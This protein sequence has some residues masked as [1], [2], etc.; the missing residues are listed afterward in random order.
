MMNT[1]ASPEIAGSRTG[2]GSHA[3]TAVTP[4]MK[5]AVSAHPCQVTGV[6]PQP[7][8]VFGPNQGKPGTMPKR[9]A[10]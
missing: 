10:R 8:L 7:K 1:I 3:D 2:N 5:P 4:A 9:Y 6:Q